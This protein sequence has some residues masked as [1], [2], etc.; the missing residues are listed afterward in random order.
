MPKTLMLVFHFL[1][2]VTADMPADVVYPVL[3]T[4]LELT[5]TYGGSDFTAS[6]WEWYKD[7]V[8]VSN[9]AAQKLTITGATNSDNGSYHCIAV[10]ARQK[11]TAATPAIPVKFH[12]KYFL[13]R[14]LKD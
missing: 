8:L 4:A 11:N 2:A 7:N 10:D 9:Q 5:C 3:G 1:S 12:S 14:H 6:T 13:T